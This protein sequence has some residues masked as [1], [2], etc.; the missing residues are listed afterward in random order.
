MA[1]YIAL[2]AAFFVALAFNHDIIN[3]SL[4]RIGWRHGG[5][6]FLILFVAMTVPFMLYEVFF[7]IRQFERRN[8]LLGI[9]A[10]AG[11]LALIP[12]AFIPYRETDPSILLGLH[13][14][15]GRIGAALSIISVTYMVAQ[16]CSHNR[17]QIKTAAVSF[18]LFCLAI[19][20]AYCTVQCAALFQV[21]SSFG[22][23]IVMFLLNRTFLKKSKEE[24]QVFAP[25]A[26][27]SI[28]AAA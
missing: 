11:A 21:G 26:A 2:Y 15:F 13:L 19:I 16:Y 5:F 22:F 4:S 27:E 17:K 12:A 18:G 28:G 24:K 3:T 8:K 9:L 10:T 6:I 14:M 1:V 23:F 25:G 20:A 7:F